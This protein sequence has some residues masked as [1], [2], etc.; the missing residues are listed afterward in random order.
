MIKEIYVKGRIS[1]KVSWT[2]D[3]IKEILHEDIVPQIYGGLIR[4]KIK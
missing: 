1:E 2:Y 4:I 3:T